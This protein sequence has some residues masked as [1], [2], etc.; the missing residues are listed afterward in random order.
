VA[1]EKGGVV[2]GKKIMLQNSTRA[3]TKKRH[4]CLTAYLVFI[5]AGISVL[6]I[7]Y[8]LR[9]LAPDNTRPVWEILLFTI[10]NFFAIICAVAIFMWK[11]WG[12]WGLCAVQIVSFIISI[13]QRDLIV[14]SAIRLVIS[15][16]LLFLV[17]DIGGDNK[18]W[19]QLE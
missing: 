15:L 4:G 8:L 16:G 12:V 5:I 3:K 18:G 17:L 14:I 19:A 13:L 6:L 2:G 10:L 11:K 1:Q 9:G 7:L